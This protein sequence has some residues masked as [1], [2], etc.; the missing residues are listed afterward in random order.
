MTPVI[1]GNSLYTIVPGP[2]WTQAEAN[3]VKL[4]GHLVTISDSSENTFVWEKFG[5]SNTPSEEKWIGLNDAETE[6]T[7][8]WSNGE[9]V[10]FTNWAY[11]APANTSGIQ[12]E[13]GKGSEAQDYANFWWGTNDGTW[14]DYYIDGNG[15]NSEGIAEIPFIRRGDSAYVIVEGPTWEEAEA[16]AVRLGGHLVTINDGKEDTFVYTR[17]LSLKPDN[18]MFIGLNDASRE[19]VFTWSSGETPDYRNF[20]PGEPSGDGAYGEEDYVHLYA[21]NAYGEATTSEWNDATNNGGN[22]HVR[23][24]IAEIPLAPNNTPTGS[25]TIAGQLKTGSTLTI[26]SSRIQDADNFIGYTPAFQYSWESSV[27]GANWMTIN[28]ADATDNTTTYTLTSAEVGKQIRAVVNYVDGYGTTET[29]RTTATTAISGSNTNNGKASFQISGSTSIGST[30]QVQQ[31]SDDLD[32][33]GTPTYSWQASTNGS[34]WSSIGSGSSYKLQTTDQGKQIRVVVSYTDAEDFDE[35]ITTSAVV[36]PAAPTPAP[37]APRLLEGTVTGDLITLA[38]DSE[39]SNTKPAATSFTVQANGK[40][41]GVFAT[42][43]TGSAGVVNLQL[44]RSIAPKETVTIAYRDL[45]GD[46]VSSVIQALDGTDVASFTANV[47]NQSTDQE[48]PVLESA[49]ITGSQALLTFSEALQSTQPA[50]TSFKL[51][52][53]GKTISITGLQVDDTAGSVV[54][55]LS[56]PVAARTA[57]TLDYKDL[58]GDQTT[59]VL[60][61]GYGNDLESFQGF[62]VINETVATINPL[63][64]S[65]AEVDGQDVT[66]RFDRELD[67]VIAPSRLF[68]VT[69]NNQNVRVTSVDT[70]TSTQEVFLGLQKPVEPGDQLLIS[71]ND[72]D[73]DQTSGVIQDQDG[74]DLASFLQLPAKNITQK[75][76]VLE[77]DT[78]EAQDNQISIQ[79]SEEIGTTS[80][81]NARFKVKVDGRS[82]PITS[83]ETDP[84]DGIVTLTLKNT[85]DPG[86]DV[87]VSYKDLKGN[88][89]SGVIEDL[90]GTDLESFSDLSATNLT[91]DEIPPELLEISVDGA[92]VLMEFDEII[93]PATIKASKFQV[94]VDGTKVKTSDAIVDQDSTFAV[95]TLPAILTAGSD[96]Q[97]SYRDPKKDQSSGVLEDLFGNDVGTFRNI[98]ATVI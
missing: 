38:F 55:T 24:G 36:I 28:T 80:P 93:N 33:N 39:L 11:V 70:V 9:D 47:S 84:G 27:D 89:T 14:D 65:S 61:D 17:L 4:G 82:N 21:R 95:L 78:I 40:N 22:G 76:T 83:V 50:L 96:V 87:L 7:W 63:E 88:Q 97:V 45:N 72:P 20:A 8:R 3:A 94:R 57:V 56:R 46:Q 49:S 92:E 58:N 26:D 5:P 73:G 81:G 54:L 90:I 53:A 29:I 79:L 75:T 12:Y 86:Q 18:M 30:L 41:V 91:T 31:T 34:S 23:Y 71:Y 25:P 68:R 77:V 42:I 44:L 64:V 98:A 85:L 16:N 35:T 52:E 1:R 19:G 62:E 15:G 67:D 43:V 13:A 48:P 69:V 59:G 2:S 10:V 74:N 6:G 60:Q 37:S 32:G 66:L 51:K